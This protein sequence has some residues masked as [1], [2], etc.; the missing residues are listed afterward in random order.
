[1]AITAAVD[2]RFVRGLPGAGPPT[3]LRPRRIVVMSN[4][5]AHKRRRSGSWPREPDASCATCHP[6]RLI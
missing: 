4:L 1:L 2:A 5:S 3:E 6:T